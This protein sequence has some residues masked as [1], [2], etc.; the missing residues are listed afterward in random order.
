[1]LPSKFSMVMLKEYCYEHTARFGAKNTEMAE[2]YYFIEH[3]EEYL[4]VFVW[5]APGLHTLTYSTMHILQVVNKLI[6]FIHLF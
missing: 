2:K 6:T 3:T 1:M 4:N 5:V